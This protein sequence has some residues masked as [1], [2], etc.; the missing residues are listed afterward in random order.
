MLLYLI[1][2]GQ[3][4]ANISNLDL[5]DAP[6]TPL[7]VSQAEAVARFLEA[8]QIRLV[9]SSP[10]RRALQTADVLCRTWG[11]DHEVWRDLLEHRRNEPHRF[12]GRTGIRELCPSA[13]C[14]S[15][16]PDDGFEFGLET[17]ETGH[18]RACAILARIRDRF[19]ATE[20]KVALVAH[21][22]FNAFL[23]LAA[24]GSRRT[25]DRT[26]EQGNACINQ[27]WL[28]QDQVRLI[29]LNETRHLA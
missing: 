24:M 14:E 6:L 26:V 28:S 5:P 27:L 25:Q 21:A 4:E 9:I 29:A 10:L 11:A 1:R 13:R 19:G 15:D 23:I 3:S 12:L 16:L 17:L 20:E 8:E 2:H 7:G 22:G 18:E